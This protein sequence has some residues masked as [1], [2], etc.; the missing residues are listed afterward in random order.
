M[1]WILGT[2]VFDTTTCKLCINA[3]N[4]ATNIL[5]GYIDADDAQRIANDPFGSPDFWSKLWI[6]QIIKRATPQMQNPLTILAQ[7]GHAMDDIKAAARQC[8]EL[9]HQDSAEENTPAIQ[10]SY[11]KAVN[12]LHQR[13]IKLLTTRFPTARVSIYGSCLSNLS[14]GKGADVDLSLWIPEAERLK[15]AFHKGE[16]EA[17]VYERDMKRF[18]YQACHKL[19]NL[20]QEF[21]GMQAITRARVPVVKGT[22]A[23]AQNPYSSD[24]S[25]K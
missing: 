1:C 4:D 3:H 7:R 21:R 2:K 17:N 13:L 6:Q 15:T 10:K 9:L 24:G 5:E 19:R 16:V 12:K 8:D 20:Q 14:L 22:Y 11:H 25:I 18:V 23:F